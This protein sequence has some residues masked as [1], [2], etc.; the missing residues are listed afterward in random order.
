MV[1]IL[2]QELCLRSD[3]D[4]AD[5]L[6]RRLFFKTPTWDA[7]DGAAQARSAE[8][9]GNTFPS[10]FP[11]PAPTELGASDSEEVSSNLADASLP[12][13][14]TEAEQRSNSLSRGGT[15]ARSVTAPL[16]RFVNGGNGPEDRAMVCVA[17]NGVHGI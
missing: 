14:P 4:E 6:P 10:S 2:A 12:G 9:Q 17:R 15:A 1:I 13:V 5:A 3:N 8:Q 11:G 7:P 16:A